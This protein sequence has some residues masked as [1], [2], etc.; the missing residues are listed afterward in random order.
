MLKALKVVFF[1]TLFL[2][3]R[4]DSRSDP[5]TPSPTV[6]TQPI[7]PQTK[8]PAKEATR[9]ERGTN[10]LPLVVKI[11]EPEKTQEELAQEAKDRHDHATNEGR[12]TDLTNEIAWF[13]GLLVV[14]TVGLVL[15]T[16]GLIWTAFRQEGHFKRTERA[17][18]F[19]SRWDK[20]P[21]V[22][23][24]NQIRAWR[25]YPVFNNSG[26][27][28]ARKAQLTI[29][30]EN[31]KTEMPDNFSFETNDT[32]R[33]IP[34]IIGP[35]GNVRTSG[36]EYDLIDIEHFLKG[37]EFAYIWGWVDYNDVFSGTERHRLEFCY[38][39]A[40]DPTIPF[41]NPERVVVMS[42]KKHNGSDDECLRKAEP[43]KD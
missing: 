33:M 6:V 5:P 39:V 8:D 16:A 36:V 35:N 10:N 7:Q 19:L 11:I 43:Y 24:D 23:H 15:A 20:Q 25:V 42:Y 12:L 26:T 13:T 9:D 3:L 22:G 27:T 30:F 2:S 32:K 37:T 18:V 28:P 1:V 14:A 29:C 21:V 17:F 40:I 38:Q 31:M 34:V 41:N 4:T